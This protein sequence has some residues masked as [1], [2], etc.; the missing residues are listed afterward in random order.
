MHSYGIDR[1]CP[2]GSCL[3][4]TLWNL[5]ANDLLNDF[6]NSEIDLYA[7][8]DDFCMVVSGSTRQSLETTA[9]NAINRRY[10][11]VHDLETR[12]LKLNIDPTRQTLN[13]NFKPSFPSE[14]CAFTD[15]SKTAD[16]VGLGVIVFKGPKPVWTGMYRLDNNNTVFQAEAS[17]ILKVIEWFKSTNYNSIDIYSDSL[18]SVSSS[19]CLY[20]KSPIV[21]SIHKLCAE[22][23]PKK[24]NLFWIKAHIG[25]FGNEVADTLAG[26]AT[27][28]NYN[29]LNV[30]LPVSYLKRTLKNELLIRWQ[31]NRD[32]SDKVFLLDFNKV[33]SS[34]PRALLGLFPRMWFRLMVDGSTCTPWHMRS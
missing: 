29:R 30:K 8:A 31:S 26:A 34:D 16:G 20:P 21:L 14:V 28:I 33:G 1:G 9:N 32:S 5:I 24:V 2:Q 6:D 27:E 17:A 19:T 7:Y 15:G 3:G 4:P 23:A 12:N 11:S 22:I 18:S 10:I 13:L 25:I